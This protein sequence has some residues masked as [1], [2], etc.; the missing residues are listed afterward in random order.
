MTNPFHETKDIHHQNF[1]DSKV[2]DKN[3][4]IVTQEAQARLVRNILRW[5]T[6]NFE[7]PDKEQAQIQQ[8]MDCL[9]KGLNNKV[10][11]CNPSYISK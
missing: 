8:F 3:V 1:D 5:H 4:Y 10:N 2:K 9:T 11:R 6:N 7:H